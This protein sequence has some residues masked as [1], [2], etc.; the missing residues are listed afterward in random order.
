MT[1][2]SRPFQELSDDLLKDSEYAAVYL[3]EVLNQGDTELFKLALKNVASAR[4]GS[5]SAVAEKTELAREALYRSLSKTGNPR[6]DT[7]TKVLEA[8]GLR[9]SVKT[10]CRKV[11]TTKAKP[12]R[13]KN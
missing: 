13:A 12:D 9:L 6:F 7:L 4:L 11:G 5:M 8:I 3:E 10:A 2:T 1:R